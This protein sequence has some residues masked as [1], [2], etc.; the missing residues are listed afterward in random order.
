MNFRT[1]HYIGF[2]LSA[3]SALGI[4]FGP[5]SASTRFESMAL[6]MLSCLFLAVLV[7]AWAIV[8]DIYYWI[9]AKLNYI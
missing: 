4:L 9:R 2:L 6:F 1:S 3:I 8:C 7:F 5:L